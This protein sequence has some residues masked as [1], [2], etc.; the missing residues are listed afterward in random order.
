MKKLF[1]SVF[2]L[3]LGAF[4]FISCND[5]DKINNDD[6]DGGRFLTVP[7][8]QQA[9]TN[10]LNGVADAIEFTEFS[11]AL[12]FVQEM[13]GREINKR[14]LI[15][16]LASP[17]IQEDT[18][19]QQKLQQALI[20]YTRDTIAIDLSPLYMS[21]DLFV[22]DTVLVD[23]VYQQ[24]EGGAAGFYVDS[25]YHTLFVL[26]NIK[27]DVDHFQLNVFIDEHELVLKAKVR[28][29]ES[30][31][32]YKNEK[33][34]KTVYLPKS[35]EVSLALDGQIIAAINGEYTSN[36]SLYVEDVKDGDDIVELDGTQFSVS[37]SIKVV[38]YELA[39]AL[40]FDLNKGIEANMAA[41]YADN[42]LLS[43]NGKL[44]A[45][46]EGLDI[47]NDTA[48][49]IWAQNPEMLKSI[50]LN[51]SMGGGK[52]EVKCT[53]DNPFKNQ[54]LANTLRSLMVPGVTLT[55]EKAKQTIE[56]LNE[57][58]NAG[59]YFEGFKQ[60]QA[61]LKFVILEEADAKQAGTK[62]SVYEE[63]EEEGNPLKAIG[64]LFEKTGAYPV[65]IARDANGNEIE[66]P[67]EEY[68]SKIDYSNLVQSLKTKFE[69]TFGQ[70]IE[71]IKSSRK[72]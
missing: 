28:A 52:V 12:G 2:A 67:F 25:T 41:K 43:I 42:E 55:E 56:Q 19:F 7:E 57:V 8:Q 34:N 66:V 60:P 9:I 32:T 36:M 49:L 45:V 46:F 63:E 10:A 58:I 27:H 54:E 70:F 51:A 37:G 53:M 17:A 20:L 33:T 3:T 14:D 72:K 16:I 69:A 22:S 24:S 38:S 1:L 26:D 18:V 39:G 29:G 47:E 50:S 68:F 64:E 13:M 23:T 6:N 5:D 21:A 30:I 31:I 44:D 59:I 40:K 71:A 4:A 11:N 65:L 62:G 15:Q 35:A 48:I 61:K